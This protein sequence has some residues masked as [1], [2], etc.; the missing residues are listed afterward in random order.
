ME[1]VNWTHFAPFLNAV[2]AG[3]ARL[4]QDLMVNAF[5][6]DADDEVWRRNKNLIA[7]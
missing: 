5:V 6:N 1:H 7:T 4:V 2:R 3:D